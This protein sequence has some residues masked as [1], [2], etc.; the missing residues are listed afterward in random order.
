MSIGGVALGCTAIQDFPFLELFDEQTVFA[1][2]NAPSVLPLLV[3]IE[4][5]EG[6]AHA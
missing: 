5:R 4:A 2:V 1:P 6:R 3:S